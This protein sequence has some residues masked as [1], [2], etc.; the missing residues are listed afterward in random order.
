MNPHSTKTPSPPSLH[1]GLLATPLRWVLGWLFFSALW[2][3]VVLAPSKLDLS[4]PGN[5]GIKLNHF[6]P[7][8]LDP[9]GTLAWTLEH[10]E[11]LRPMLIVVTIVEGLAGLGLLLG[12]FTRLSGALTA[13][14]SGVILF[15]AGWL[16][17]TC[18]DEWQIGVLGIAGGAV[19][20]LTGS[21]P[22][23]LDDRLARNPERRDRAWFQWCCTGPLPRP[24]GTMTQ[25]WIW[26]ISFATLALTLSTNQQFHGG[27]WGPLHNLSAKPHVQFFG[28]ESTSSATTVD[29]MRD[30]GPD[31][32]GAFI[33]AMHWIDRDGQALKTLDHVD[34]SG[35]APSQIHNRYPAQV[36]P[37]PFGLVLPLGARATLTLPPPPQG[38]SGLR[39]VEVS[40]RAWDVPLTT[41]P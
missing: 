18:L 11:V 35:L 12:L 32:H 2:R 41:S 23:A 3:R 34:L 33:V 37:G 1:P 7:H 28:A 5:L 17:T 4:A 20:A 10:P 13:F 29:L 26:A 38:A 40:G 21:G 24:L 9:T 6:L 8:A 30:E 15:S 27:V 19:V 39:W 16:G 25:R 14:L 22:I 31:T 36:Q